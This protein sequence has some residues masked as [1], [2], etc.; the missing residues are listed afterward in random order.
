M[1]RSLKCRDVGMDCDF[2]TTGKD[3]NEVMQKAAAHA[4]EKHG[5]ASIPPDMEKKAR[6]AIKDYRLP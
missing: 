1:K 5:M 4:K 6:S 3:D 2:Q